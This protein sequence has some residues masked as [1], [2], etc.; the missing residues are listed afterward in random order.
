MNGWMGHGGWRSSGCDTGAHHGGIPLVPAPVACFAMIFGL[1]MGLMVGR[2]KGRR[3]GMGPGAWCG[4]DWP[5]R[6]KMMAHHHHGEGMP[7]CRC[8]GGKESPAETPKT[9]GEN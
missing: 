4:G 2:M 9:A 7:A 6:D 1:M 8:G 5:M 3:H